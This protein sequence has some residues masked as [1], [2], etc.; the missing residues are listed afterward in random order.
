MPPTRTL[1]SAGQA[2]GRWTTPDYR[3]SV[4]LLHYDHSGRA[5]SPPRHAGCLHAPPT[6]CAAGRISWR[7]TV[8]SAPLRGPACLHIRYLPVPMPAL[9]G[10]HTDGAYATRTPPCWQALLPIL[11]SGGTGAGHR[12]AH[13]L[14]T[15]GTFTWRGIPRTPFCYTCAR[16]FRARRLYPSH[17][18]AALPNWNIRGHCGREGRDGGCTAFIRHLHCLPPPTL[19]AGLPGHTLLSIHEH[20][21]PLSLPRGPLWF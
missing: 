6:T 9:S 14:G 3:I 15:P 4:T 18:Y 1:S 21:A 2:F 8:D 16:H 19:L 7:W 13:W 11:L 5:H 12:A 17:A 10:R 20:T